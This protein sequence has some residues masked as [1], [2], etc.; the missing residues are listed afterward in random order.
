[1]NQLEEIVERGATQR[2]ALQKRVDGL[3]REHGSLQGK[4]AAEQLDRQAAE[5]LSADLPRPAAN[6]CSA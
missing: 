1:M 5:S 2:P 3:V 6:M 4:L